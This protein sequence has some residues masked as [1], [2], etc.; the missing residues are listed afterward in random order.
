MSLT[1]GKNILVY[2]ET[3]GDAPVGPALEI[4]AKAKELAGAKGEEV[5]AAVLAEAPEAAAQTAI[6]AGADEAVVVKTAEKCGQR[7][8]QNW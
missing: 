7:C 1:E 3:A 2:V 8:L 6:E 4:L 5:I